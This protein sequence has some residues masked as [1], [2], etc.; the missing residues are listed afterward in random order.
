M[1]KWQT[2]SRR[3][4]G[5]GTALLPLR[6]PAHRATTRNLQALYPFVID[7]G[8]GTQGVYVGRQSG[9]D[10][11]FVHD[12]W[13]HY[14]A[15]VVTNP[16]ILLAGVIGRGKSALAKSLALRL[17]AFGVRIYVPGDPKGEWAPVAEALGTEP[18]TLG[19]GLSTRINPLDPGQRPH[20]MRESDWLR[21]VQVRR[22]ALLAALAETTLERRL[23]PVERTALHLAVETV[24]SNRAPILPEV[25]HALM[26]PHPDAAASVNMTAREL[27]NESRNLALELR[28]LVVGDLAGL[29]DGPTTHPLDF[30]RK[31]LIERRE[32]GRDRRHADDRRRQRNQVFDTRAH[33]RSAG[34]S[35]TTRLPSHGR[36]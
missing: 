21:E 26:S 16:N 7:S 34:K 33:A 14:R 2:S 10:A 27:V 17:S 29:F 5:T 11:S 13:Q 3:G 9:T 8:L 19:R 25:V 31:A 22:L 1:K 35:C 18:I 20:D 30:A 12:P 15:G 23:A 24:G 28:R 4:K 32:S 6:M 36:R